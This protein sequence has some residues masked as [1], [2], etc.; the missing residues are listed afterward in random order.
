MAKPAPAAEDQL[1]LFKTEETRERWRWVH[2]AIAYAKEANRT[3]MQ[4]TE[5]PSRDVRPALRRV[6]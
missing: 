2:E 1:V 4:M 5:E 6:R 3:A